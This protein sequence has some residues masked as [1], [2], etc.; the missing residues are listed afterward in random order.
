M[1]DIPPYVHCTFRLTYSHHYT[2]NIYIFIIRCIIF[3]QAFARDSACVKIGFSR[4]PQE[5]HFSGIESTPFSQ[6]G[7]VVADNKIDDSSLKLR[8]LTHP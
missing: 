5:S 2:K 1:S 6:L 4:F 3:L 8:A 7:L